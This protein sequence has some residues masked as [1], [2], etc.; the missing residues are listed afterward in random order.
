MLT[1]INPLIK[2][3]SL[4]TDTAADFIL[5][6]MN[7]EVILKFTSKKAFKEFLKDVGKVKKYMYK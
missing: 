4:H 1:V 6:G 2:N 7:T 5:I 3:Q